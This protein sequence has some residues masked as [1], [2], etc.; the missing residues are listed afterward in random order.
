[1]IVVMY[2]DH[3]LN[4]R[5][6]LWYLTGKPASGGRRRE[7]MQLYETPYVIWTNY[8]LDTTTGAQTAECQLS[9]FLDAEAGRC[10]AARST[11]VIC[12][13]FAGT[14]RW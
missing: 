2:G 4:W 12:C 3:R 14:S 13:S 6:V 5:M 8:P 10:A 7:T 9:V 11:T 1:M